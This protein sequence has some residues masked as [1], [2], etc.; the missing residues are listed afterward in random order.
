MNIPFFTSKPS[1]LDSAIDRAFADLA[2]CTVASDQYAARM[3][4]IN[5]LYKL[6][7][8]TASKPVSKDTLI[9]VAGNLIGIFAILYHE[10]AHVITTKA[11]G[12]VIK[13]AK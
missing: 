7:E 13:A 3:D 12:F 10:Q 9:L 4:E 2:K 1:A 5:K 8:Q 6:K 11:L